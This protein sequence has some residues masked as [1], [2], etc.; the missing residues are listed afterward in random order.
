MSQVIISRK[1]SIHVLDYLAAFTAGTSLLLIQDAFVIVA[2]AL[3]TLDVR[4]T[5]SQA[6]ISASLSTLLLRDGQLFIVLR[7]SKC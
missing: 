2:T 7:I 6:G 4:R 5:A 3:K 1:H